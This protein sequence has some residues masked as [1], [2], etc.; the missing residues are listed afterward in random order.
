MTG[1]HRRYP[2]LAEAEELLRARSVDALT[3]DVFDTV[4]WRLVP[5][6]IDIFVLLGQRLH[7]QRALHATLTPAAFGALRTHAERRAREDLLAA[8]GRPEVRLHE[9]W[10][11]IPGWVHAPLGRAE[12]V[13]L[14]LEVEREKLVP[15]LE[16]AHLLS[17]A[18][19]LEIPVYAISDTYFSADQLAQ[20]FEQPLLSG[21]RFAH[22]FTSSDHRSNKSGELFDHALRAIGADPERVLHIGDNQ[23]ADLEPPLKRGMRALH[24]PR[25]PDSL[26]HLLRRESA[27]RR[28]RALAPSRVEDAIREDVAQV[29]GSLVQL[30]AKMAL[31]G[32]EHSFPSSQQPFW[33]YGA[34]VL[35][36]ILAGFADWVVEQTV[37]LGARHAHCLMREGEFLGE[38][39]QSAAD[40][41][42]VDL[43]VT[44]LFLNRQLTTLASIGDG[45]ELELERLL[46][47]RE[48]PTVRQ[49]VTMLGVDPQTIPELA[50]HLDSALDEGMRRAETLEFLAHNPLVVQAVQ[51]RTRVLRDRIVRLLDKVHPDRDEPMVLVDLGW[52]ASIERRIVQLLR[53]ANHPAA[54]HGLYLV[55]HEGAVE[56]VAQG[57][58]VSGFLAQFGQPSVISDAV[59]RS[60]EILEQVCMPAFGTQIDLTPDLEPVLADFDLP[61]AQLAEASA[62]RDGV[63]AFQRT[64]LRYRTTLPTKVP[65]LGDAAAQLAPIAARSCVDPTAEEALQF[66]RWQHDAGQGTDDVEVLAASRWA[67]LIRHLDPG[68]L[69]SLPMQEVYWPAAVARLHDPHFA[70][71]SAAQAAGLLEEGAATAE[72]E[73]GEM[74]IEASE[75]ISLDQSTAVQIVPRRNRH[76]LSL[77]RATLRAGHIKRIQIRLSTRPAIFRIDRLRLVMHVKDDDAPLV[78]RL[79]DPGN[80]HMIDTL[81]AARFSS[82]LVGTLTDDGYLGFSTEHLLAGRIV[83]RIDVEFAFAALAWDP[84][85]SSAVRRTSTAELERELNSARSAYDAVVGSASW[86]M[87]KP[88]RDAKERLVGRHLQRVKRRLTAR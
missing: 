72:L 6:P 7:A 22:L 24:I 60:P 29:D 39:I 57:G 44:R 86:R 88:L 84:Q 50:G 9:I 3:L 8:T 42:G 35:G 38:L 68:Q 61:P 62:A 15:D 28:T 56:T 23:H 41:R 14:E 74:T 73:T 11:R 66:G 53:Q 45:N 51:E 18:N 20:L 43:D 33:R 82:R 64:Y 87:T 80:T 69:L 55:T 12:A 77:V 17:V 30:R 40:A 26:S 54:I 79:D 36:P 27:Y 52:G 81:N 25:R 47:R 16:I 4:L 59:M 78:L 76:G 31:Y 48:A 65:S 1:A 58:A 49:F 83:H 63:R 5:E 13:R 19:E 67:D 70:D 46:A 2:Q 37:A 85:S 75:G 10:Q 34:E 32:E 21:L 71:I